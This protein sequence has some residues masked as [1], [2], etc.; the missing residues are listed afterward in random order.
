MCSFSK[1]VYLW[2]IHISYIKALI[3]CH[4]K[5]ISTSVKK[6]PKLV[7]TYNFFYVLVLQIV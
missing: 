2:L 5:K 6:T 3:I 4:I 7:L 1:I